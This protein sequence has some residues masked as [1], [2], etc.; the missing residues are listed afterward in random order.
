MSNHYTIFLTILL[1]CPNA[2]QTAFLRCSLL[3]RWRHF[4]PR[5]DKFSASQLYQ[6]GHD[7][8]CI[9]RISSAR[10]APVHHAQ[11]LK[12]HVSQLWWSKH[13]VAFVWFLCC[14][15]CKITF[16][17]SFKARDKCFC[18]LLDER[19]RQYFAVG[20]P[21]TGMDCLYHVVIFMWLL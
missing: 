11:P 1:A 5:S 4:V 3:F 9:S 18:P 17:L 19:W 21:W 8:L 2:F 15:L 10:R 7:L 13:D 16:C 14:R 6:R 12:R 20:Q